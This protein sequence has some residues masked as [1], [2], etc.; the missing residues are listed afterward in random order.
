MSPDE[1][2]KLVKNS[3]ERLK[4]IEG[5]DKVRFIILYGSAVEGITREESDIDLCID[6]DAETDYEGSKFRLK[7]LSELP[8]FFDVQIFSQLPLYVKKEVLKG[9]VVFCRDVEY[10]YEIALLTI[11]EFEDFKYRFYDYIGE[12]AIA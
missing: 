3:V 1:I 4:K 10:L 6:I 2:N 12:R 8:D 7:V 11:K 5:F 9:K